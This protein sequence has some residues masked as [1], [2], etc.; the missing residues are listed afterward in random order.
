LGWTVLLVEVRES[1]EETNE[2]D[3]PSDKKKGGLKQ[4]AQ[5]RY[6]RA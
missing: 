2:S 1:I 3:T 6:E 4:P 5:E